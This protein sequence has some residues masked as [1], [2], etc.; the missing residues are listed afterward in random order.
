MKKQLVVLTAF[1]FF[2]SSVFAQDF[3]FAVGKVE[4]GKATLTLDKNI[5]CISL[6]KN[7][8]AASQI[9][10]TYNKVELV[11]QNDIFYALV[12]SGATFL[13]TFAVKNVNGV[14]LAKVKVSCTT[15]GKKCSL[16][17]RACT[18]SQNVGDCACTA[19]PDDEICTKTCS[20]EDLIGN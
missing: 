19:C 9:K 7:I 18:A 8:L 2:V 12:F 10:E 20:S 11:Q 13:T 17:G 4:S 14:L 15:T 3:D 1:L 16:D 6:S 5:A